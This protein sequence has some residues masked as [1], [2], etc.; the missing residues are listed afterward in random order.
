MTP[1]TGVDTP[2]QSLASNRPARKTGSILLVGHLLP[3][4]TVSGCTCFSPQSHLL[5]TF[6]HPCIRGVSQIKRWLRYQKKLPCAKSH[7]PWCPSVMLSLLPSSKL[8][9]TVANFLP[10]IICVINCTMPANITC[11]SILKAS[12]YVSCSWRNQLIL[13]RFMCVVLRVACGLCVLG[14]GC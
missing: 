1:V 4:E 5:V 7:L 8:L 12:S 14:V 6:H 13:L 10:F 3:T 9:T 11:S 2:T